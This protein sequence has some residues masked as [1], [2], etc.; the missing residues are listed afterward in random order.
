MIYKMQNIDLKLTGNNQHMP[1]YIKISCFQ[2][3]NQM[4]IVRY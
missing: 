1:R 4:K 3:V 2:K